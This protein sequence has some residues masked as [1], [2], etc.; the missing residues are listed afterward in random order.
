MSVIS[1]DPLI[2]IGTSSSE[3][4]RSLMVPFYR[5]HF[6]GSTI[7]SSSSS[8]SFSSPSSNLNNEVDIFDELP[9]PVDSEGG[10]EWESPSASFNNEFDVF[11]ELPELVDSESDNEW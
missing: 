3:L 4:H 8:T 10:V 6:M 7:L 5:T 2:W 1:R 11:D 9:E